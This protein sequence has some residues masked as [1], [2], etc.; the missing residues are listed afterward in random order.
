M[1]YDIVILIVRFLFSFVSV[2]TVFIYFGA[3]Y[4]FKYRKASYY[5]VSGGLFMIVL[6][7]CSL[8]GNVCINFLVPIA[9][10]VGFVFVF[11]KG[12][13]LTQ[14]A[15]I[16]AFYLIIVISETFV[17]L[18]VNIFDNFTLQE[19]S[20]EKISNIQYA[21]ISS[22]FKFMIFNLIIQ[23]HING[24]NVNKTL[25]KDF[26]LIVP[27]TGIYMTATM[28]VFIQ[29]YIINEFKPIVDISI[30]AA[31]LLL[32]FIIVYFFTIA[33][34][35]AKIEQEQALIKRQGKMEMERYQELVKMQQNMKVIWHD[36]SNHIE[37]TKWLMTNNR[38]EAGEYLNLLETM[39]EVYSPVAFSE[40][41]VVDAV[42]CG[43]LSKAKEMG[44]HTEV[45]L[46]MEKNIAI[47]QIDLC[48][49][50]SNSLDNAIEASNI[51]KGKKAI[52]LTAVRDSGF[53]LI[54]IINTAVDAG[55]RDLY[56]NIVTG[57]KDKDRHGVG[58]KSISKVAEK[59]DGYMNT[60]FENGMFK[61]SILLNI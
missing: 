31:W 6:W 2:Y 14:M 5:I 60:T 7:I 26:L 58:L 8:F 16:F 43:K 21:L 38:T 47:D 22:M 40:N 49:I 9:V 10:T 19:L 54:Q 28:L 57:K 61:L 17:F 51:V 56:G 23:L 48:S 59:Y 20:W 18:F 4:E 3:F 12:E 42:L 33:R 27:A 11:Y 37:C 36:I 53:L 32:S 41:T 30:G 13:K 50:F 55:K 15:R 34:K 39:V 24:K 52:K 29:G 45:N 35:L 25:F 1:I 44:I 46:N